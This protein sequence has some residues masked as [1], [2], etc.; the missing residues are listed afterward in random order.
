M[1][2]VYQ[3]LSGSGDHDPDLMYEERYYRKKM[4]PGDMV[5]FK[6]VEYETDLFVAVAKGVPVVDLKSA[7]AKEIRR[8][9]RT[10]TD[11]QKV[12]PGFFECLEPQSVLPGD[13]EIV[14]RMKRAGQAAGVG[15]MAA[16]AG[17]VSAQVADGA[18]SA[19]PE[20]ILENGGDLLVR[21]KK[22]RRVAV[23]T[24]RSPFKGL[25]LILEGAD[26]PR[27]I[28][29]SSGVMG[30]SL[31][32]GKADAATVISEDVYLADAVATAL[33]NRLKSADDISSALAWIQK[34]PGILGA[35][36]I[37]EG[38]LGAWGDIVLD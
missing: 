21:T 13:P 15:P 11:Y 27:G 32:F 4:V 28:C 10:L 16:V 1:Y 29:T 17:A 8:A 26:A 37:I 5:A 23:E 36:V 14:T 6:S 33:G 30:H 3:G 25:K 19:C 7:V 24:G 35:L 9:R 22:R 18:L 31:S 20:F 12:H 2:A 34:I 38:Q